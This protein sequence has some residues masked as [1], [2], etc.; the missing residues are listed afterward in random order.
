MN[1]ATALLRTHSLPSLIHHSFITHSVIRKSDLSTT[2]LHH[3]KC[4]EFVD[5]GKRYLEKDYALDCD[6]DRYKAFT[7]FALAMIGVYPIGK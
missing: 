3:S 7:V 6:G 1:G 5:M 4:D 2:L